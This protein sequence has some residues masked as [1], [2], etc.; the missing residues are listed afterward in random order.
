[1]NIHYL[2]HVT[3]EDTAYI[4]EWAMLKHHR[5]T[6]TRMFDNPVL[7]ALDTIDWLIVMGGPMSVG[8]D[9]LYPWL[10]DEKKYIEQAM[11]L[12]KPLVGICLGAQII[13]SVLGAR[14]YKNQHKEIGWF[15]VQLTYPAKH[16]AVFSRLPESFYA[17]H[18]HGDTFDIPSGA[19]WTA[20]SEA[21]AHQAFEYGRKVIGLQFHLESTR[22]SIGNLI[23]NCHA[24]IDGSPYVQ[25][26]QQMHLHF[27]KIE[28][29]NIVLIQIFDA[30]HHTIT[31]EG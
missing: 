23:H 7:P 14:V 26:E 20:R 3:F 19:L 28:Q 16:S 8:E 11:N 5:L 21:C 17:F 15:P 18:W 27:D 6:C 12:G 24:D 31:Q 22:D 29:S 13:A 25:S 2:Q 4:N 10:T 30:L 9:H 1:M